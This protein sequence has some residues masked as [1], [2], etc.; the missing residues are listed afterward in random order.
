[1][2]PK[3]LRNLKRLIKSG[4]EANIRL[5]D[6]LANDRI[7]MLLF[8]WLSDLHSFCIRRR[9]LSI[10]KYKEFWRIIMKKISELIVLH[11]KLTLYK[12]L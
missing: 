1:M 5:F 7:K 6:A 3:E 2:T 8:K 9:N 11:G 10:E 4:D 12:G